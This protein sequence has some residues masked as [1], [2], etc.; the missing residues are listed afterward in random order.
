MKITKIKVPGLSKEAAVERAWNALEGE[1]SGTRFSMVID[2]MPGGSLKLSKIRLRESKPYCGNHAK[3][4]ERS[5]LDAILGGRPHRRSKYLEGADWVEFNDRLNDAMDRFGVSCS[6]RSSDCWI[7]KGTLR[8]IAYDAKT[9]VGVPGNGEWRWDRDACPEDWVE[10][11]DLPEDFRASWFPEGT[12]GIH[13]FIGY[14]V[15]G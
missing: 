15:V 2:A 4:C 6:I 11:K 12:P 1:F 5:T 9:F 10:A 8:R 13:E 7:R 3:A 14:S